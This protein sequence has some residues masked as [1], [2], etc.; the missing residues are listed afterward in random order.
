MP[1]PCPS[2]ISDRGTLTILPRTAP[3]GALR[4]I[5]LVAAAVFLFALADTVTK[6]LTMAFP[7]PLVVAVRYL[8]SWLLVI[9][10]FGPQNGR[11][12]W[13]TRRTGLVLLRSLCLAAAS[14]TM[15]L[16]LRTL[17]VGETVSIVY[18]A[19]FVVLLLA[20]PLLG[21]KVGLVAWIG[22]SVSFAGVLAIMRPGG[23]LDPTGVAFALAN[24]LFG[25]G[26]H[27][28]TRILSRSETTA[29]LM[30]HTMLTGWIVFLP[31][32]LMTLSAA[33]P[34]PV[35]FLWMGILGVLATGGHILFTNA[36][37]HAGAPTLAPINYL[38]LV[39]AALLGWLIFGHVPDS[40]AL[41]GMAAILLA[42]LAVTLLSRSP[43]PA[44]QVE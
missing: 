21:E 23:G 28:L 26:Y 1:G 20:G 11:A 18:L 7:V 2:E 30:F 12:L 33:D 38:H 37:R 13:R 39:W 25:T 6:R 22:A 29:A 34:A 14:L 44:P 41:G 16:A 36:Y 40:I 9:A 43:T 8:A 15:G 19:P 31:F 10:A 24:V 35:D 42:G 32:A 27:L 3:S 5:L 4:G 17:P